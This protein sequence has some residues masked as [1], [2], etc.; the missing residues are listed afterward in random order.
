VPRQLW[1]EGRGGAGCECVGGCARR[2]IL[3]WGVAGWSCRE[4]CSTALSLWT[5]CWLP[6]PPQC[7]FAIVACDGVWDV[8][9]DQEAV[10]MVRPAP[11]ASS[12]HTHV[13]LGRLHQRSCA[14][15]SPLASPPPLSHVRVCAHKRVW[16]VPVLC[17]GACA[18]VFRA[19]VCLCVC[20]LAPRFA[21]RW[22]GRGPCWVR[23]LPGVPRWWWTARLPGGPPTTSPVWWC[24]SRSRNDPSPPL[25]EPPSLFPALSSPL[26]LV[27]VRVVLFGW[28][29]FFVS[30]M[31][32]TSSLPP[33]NHP[34]E[35]L[36]PDVVQCHQVRRRC[37]R[38]ALYR[39]PLAC[40]TM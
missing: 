14:P 7:Q 2:G 25:P 40:A 23:P 31:A 36:R 20:A 10:D 37:L 13:F 30:L 18:Q 1:W 16:G 21:R 27:P 4:R 38:R 12:S 15:L 26:W 33:T 24:S 19:R 8:M 39:R 35:P 3:S 5:A 6:V 32:L 17:L 34:Q 11:R 22:R 29:S 9:S 28:D